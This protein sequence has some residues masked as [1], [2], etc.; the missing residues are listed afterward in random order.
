[1]DHNTRLETKSQL[2]DQFFILVSRFDHGERMNNWFISVALTSHPLPWTLREDWLYE[3]IDANGKRLGFQV[4]QQK[5]LDLI[6]AANN[7]QASLALTF[8]EE[9]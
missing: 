1:L 8:D 5:G 4:K 6:K 7:Y 2:R 3:V 9:S